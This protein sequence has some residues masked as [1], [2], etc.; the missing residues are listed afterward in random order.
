MLPQVEC[1]DQF[2]DTQ[3]INSKHLTYICLQIYTVWHELWDIVRHTSEW[4][5]QVLEIQLLKWW[6]CEN[7]EGAISRGFY[8]FVSRDWSASNP[9]SNVCSYYRNAN[10]GPVKLTT[11]VCRQN[12]RNINWKCSPEI[13]NSASLTIEGSVTSDSWQ[14]TSWA[15]VIKAHKT[16][17][18]C[19]QGNKAA[20][21]LYNQHSPEIDSSTNE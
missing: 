21:P 5:T 8:N 9:F 3:A 18:I 17:S 12:K 10:R 2:N 4:V 1:K 13:I 7:Q 14:N 15:G 20:C 19:T 11:N 16:I 6:P